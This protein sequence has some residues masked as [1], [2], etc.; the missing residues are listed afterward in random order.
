MAAVVQFLL[1]AAGLLLALL[2]FAHPRRTALYLDQFAERLQ[3]FSSIT[4]RG[5]SPMTDRY[6]RAMALTFALLFT[7]ALCLVASQMAAGS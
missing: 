2:A 1:C 5:V 3:A 7:I 6:V 4:A